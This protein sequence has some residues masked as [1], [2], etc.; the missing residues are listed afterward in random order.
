MTFIAILSLLMTA[1]SA[2][3]SDSISIERDITYASVDG[4]D[5]KLDVYWH[6]ESSEPMPLVVWI[7]GGAWQRGSK[8]TVYTTDFVKDGYAIASAPLL[9]LRLCR[10]P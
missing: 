8:E 9:P 5:L 6:P 10:D 3:I 1:A 2:D 4:K 7:H